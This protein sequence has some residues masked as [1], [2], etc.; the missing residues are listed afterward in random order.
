MKVETETDVN[1]CHE[2]PNCYNTSNDHDDPFTAA[3]EGY[4]VCLVKG[5]PGRDINKI[6]DEFNIFKH[7]H[8]KCPLNENKT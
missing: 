3:P 6:T 1:C 5:G 7:I 8:K 4:F 2:C